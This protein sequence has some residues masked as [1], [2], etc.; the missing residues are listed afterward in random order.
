MALES[1][2]NKQINLSTNN[3]YMT[4]RPHNGSNYETT[5]GIMKHD[6]AQNKIVLNYDTT[7]LIL[8]YEKKI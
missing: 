5:L 2:H 1:D 6:I 8:T 3:D 7:S 4:S